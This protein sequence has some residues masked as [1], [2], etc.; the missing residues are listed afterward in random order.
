MKPEIPIQRCVTTTYKCEGT[1]E[2]LPINS[3][4]YGLEFNLDVNFS[5]IELTP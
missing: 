2:E 5:K 4:Y 1:K 3:V